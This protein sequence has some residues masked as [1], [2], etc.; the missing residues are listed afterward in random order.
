MVGDG[1]FLSAGSLARL[2][3]LPIE[4]VCAVNENDIVHKTLSKGDFSVTNSV[5]KTWAS[6]MDIQVCALGNAFL[7]VLY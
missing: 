6:S 3:G 5:V 1:F 2:M 4:I 7:H